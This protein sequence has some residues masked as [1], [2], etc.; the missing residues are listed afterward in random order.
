MIYRNQDDAKPLSMSLQAGCYPGFRHFFF[1]D[2][3][4]LFII[5]SK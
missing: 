4:T 3:G 2:L 1:V 5:H